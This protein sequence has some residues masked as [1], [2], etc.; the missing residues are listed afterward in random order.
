MKATKA[1]EWSK[2]NTIDSKMH[3]FAIKPSPIIGGASTLPDK[4]K[5]CQCQY[6]ACQHVLPKPLP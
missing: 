1:K 5:C 6:K 2:N 4:V 3:F